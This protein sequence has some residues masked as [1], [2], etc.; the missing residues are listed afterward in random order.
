MNDL[1]KIVSCLRY[2]NMDTIQVKI[3]VTCNQGIS[4]R[5]YVPEAK[6]NRKR[7]TISI[8]RGNEYLNKGG[9]SAAGGTKRKE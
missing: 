3:F 6:K 2:R 8:D 1:N 5:C 7:I 4:S 9:A